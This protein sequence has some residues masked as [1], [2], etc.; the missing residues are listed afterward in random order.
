[1]G[2]VIIIIIM[3]LVWVVRT[4]LMGPINALCSVI[5]GQRIEKTNKVKDKDFY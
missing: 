2:H 1:M 4:F 5:C 3:V